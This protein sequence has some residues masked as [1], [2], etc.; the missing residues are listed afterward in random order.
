[1]PATEGAGRALRRRTRRTAFWPAGTEG[2]RFMRRCEYDHGCRAFAAN[3]NA[4]A[5]FERCEKLSPLTKI[6]INFSMLSLMIC[7][8]QTDCRMPSGCAC[9]L[10]R[11]LR[12][13]PPQGRNAFFRPCI[14]LPGRFLPRLGPPGSRAAP[15]FSRPHVEPFGKRMSGE[16][17][18]ARPVTSLRRWEET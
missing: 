18:S 3:M 2:A 1:M 16:P 12:N 13:T 9:I 10:A 5:R 15:F 4:P 11:A 17:D 7:N 6:S 8:F 14:A